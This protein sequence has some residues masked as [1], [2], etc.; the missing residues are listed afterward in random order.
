MEPDNSLTYAFSS[1]PVRQLQTL[2]HVRTDLCL[3]EGYKE[4][5]FSFTEL[6]KTRL[7]FE[8]TQYSLLNLTIY[9]PLHSGNL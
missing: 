5:S 7:D 9:A 1:L 8:A 4:I 6:V 2:N 3:H